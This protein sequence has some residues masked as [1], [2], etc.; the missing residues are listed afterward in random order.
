M[1]IQELGYE[2]RNRVVICSNFG[3]AELHK[4]ESK[5]KKYVDTSF[6]GNEKI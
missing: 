5:R 4:E 1:K 6:K 2:L 3:R